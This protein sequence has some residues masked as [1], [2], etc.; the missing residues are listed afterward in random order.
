L[1]CC[2]HWNWCEWYVLFF[3]AK[4]IWIRHENTACLGFVFGF[5]WSIQFPMGC[6]TLHANNNNIP[7]TDIA[8][9]VASCRLIHCTETWNDFHRYVSVIRTRHGNGN[10]VYGYGNGYDNG[11]R[12]RIRNS[13]NQALD[14]LCQVQ[15]V[16]VSL[17]HTVDCVLHCTVHTGHPNYNLLGPSQQL[18]LKH[19]TSR[20]TASAASE[21]EKIPHLVSLVIGIWTAVSRSPHPTYVKGRHLQK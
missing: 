17:I 15:R 3:A 6:H 21:T 1:A 5:Q 16:E 20:L 18:G 12:E 8:V 4:S 10:G 14:S 11:L 19:S 9:L 13:G 2:Q 7:H